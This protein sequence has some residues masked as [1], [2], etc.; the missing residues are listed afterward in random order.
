MRFF[1]IF[2]FFPSTTTSKKINYVIVHKY[3]NVLVFKNSRRLHDL[4]FAPSSPFQLKVFLSFIYL[5]YIVIYLLVSF[6]SVAYSLGIV[7]LLTERENLPN[8]RT[9]LQKEVSLFRFII[10]CRLCL[11]SRMSKMYNIL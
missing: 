9:W 5:Y 8:I 4:A 1:F 6:Y 3:I 7:L 11:E 10:I 2:Y